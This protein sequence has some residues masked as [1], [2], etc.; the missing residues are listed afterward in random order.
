MNL[1]IKLAPLMAALFFQ[2]LYGEIKPSNMTSTV[3]PTDAPQTIQDR[4]KAK[5]QENKKDAQ[6]KKE[7][8][9][10]FKM[11]TM[12]QKSLDYFHPGILVF[13]NGKWEGNDHLLNLSD[14]IGVYVHVIKAE[15]DPLKISESELKKEIEEIFQ[16]A[17]IKPNTLAYQDQ[18]PLPAFEIEILIYPIDKGYVASCDGRLFESVFL[19]R[20]VLEK[21]MAFEAITWEKKSLIVGPTDKFPEQLRTNIKEIA[22][23]FA[24]RFQAYEKLKQ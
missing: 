3:K 22:Q 11:P 23:T 19:S 24:S 1:T 8:V 14:N 20:F 12:A 9:P 7:I 18:A 17:N 16:K 4:E 21:G 2:H 6:S 10:A 13:Q 15:G 5:N